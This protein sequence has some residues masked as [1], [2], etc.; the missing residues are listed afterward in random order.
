MKENTNTNDIYEIDLLRI[1]KVLWHRLWIL[2]LAGIIAG[3]V[4]FSYAYYMIEPQ[5]QS[6]VLL[7]V[8]NSAVSI[9]STEFVVN[10]AQLSTA[11]RLVD[12]YIV[13]L[14][15]RTTLEEVIEQSGANYSYEQLNGM[16]SASAV[17]GTEIFKV[18]VRS[19]DAGE[20]AFLANTISRVLPQTISDVMGGSD[21]RVVDRAVVSSH[22]VSP[23]FTKYAAIG[24]LIGVIISSL[25]VL[26]ADMRDD[27][28]HD[29]DYLTQNYEVPVLATIPNL[30]ITDS[31]TKYAGGYS[32]GYSSGR[33][34]A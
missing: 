2:I 30:S 29:V 4:A 22:R 11:Q 14:K 25:L 8:N 1:F 5:Y 32:Y 27:V 33:K 28:I 23:S 26:L 34:G 9:G 19:T 13:I 20:A 21:V 7:Y 10:S 18:N 3:G 6:S 16:V 24:V 17:N 12:T 31:G 15:S